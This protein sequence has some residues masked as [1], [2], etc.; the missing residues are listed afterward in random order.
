M[1]SRTAVPFSQ[2][3]QHPKP[4]IAKL[5]Q[6]PRRRLRLDRRD[7][8]DLILESAARAEAEDEAL[9]M[10]SRLSGPSSSNSFRRSGHPLISAI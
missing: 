6:D 8:D 7:G 3:V 4:T 2:L 10:A 5:E 1:G 9:N